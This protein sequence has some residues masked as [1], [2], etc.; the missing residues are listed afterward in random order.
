MRG[1]NSSRRLAFEPSFFHVI[2]ETNMKAS[3][4]IAALS[5]VSILAASAPALADSKMLT[6]KAGMTVYTFDKDAAGK[7]SCNDACAK[8]WPPVSVET[9]AANSDLSAVTRDD[10]SKQAAYMG[11]PIYLY[12]P[13]QKPGDATGNGFKNVWHVVPL[14]ERA[15]PAAAPASTGY[16]SGY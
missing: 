3:H 12:A 10:G 15:K 6:D 8:L 13:D 4:Q 14:G 16:S 5:F 7:S 11:K 1:C 2:E 9:M